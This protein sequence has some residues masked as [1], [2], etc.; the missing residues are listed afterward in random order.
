M[1]WGAIETGWRYLQLD[2]DTNVYRIDLSLSG[3]YLG[4]SLTF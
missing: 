2:Y 4:V 1:S 3:P